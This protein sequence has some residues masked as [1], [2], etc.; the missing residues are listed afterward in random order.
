MSNKNWKYY[1]E[2]EDFEGAFDRFNNAPK[3]WR[4]HWFDVCCQIADSCKE[5]LKKYVID[6]IEKTITI[7]IPK[8]RIRKNYQ[9]D[10]NNIDL[11]DN[12]EQKVY[13]FRFFNADG[14]RICSKV[15]TTTRKVLTRLREEL[16]SK[17]YA[18][19]GATSA[20]IDRVYDCG[21][22][23]AEGLESRFRAEYIKIYPNLF[24]KNDRFMNADFDLEE[25]DKIA[26]NYLKEKV[27]I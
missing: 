7:K 8:A 17:T 25:A 15:G 23:P 21:N 19:M 6:R 20:I 26:Y 9:I 18:A 3:N 11:L 4:S 27:I 5:W 1:I 10:T 14:D 2:E 24:K 22:L 16:N 12:A 13:L